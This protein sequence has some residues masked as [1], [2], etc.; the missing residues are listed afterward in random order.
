MQAK[1]M[2]LIVRIRKKHNLLGNSSPLICHLRQTSASTRSPTV[3]T[4]RGVMS[5]SKRSV[6]SANTTQVTERPVGFR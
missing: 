2:S 3:L 1:T 4:G 5:V 6:V